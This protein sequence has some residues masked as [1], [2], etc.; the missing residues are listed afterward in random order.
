M[1]SDDGQLALQKALV[2]ALRG[3]TDAGPNVFDRVPSSNPFP[4]VTLGPAQALPNLADCMDGTETFLQ[5][6]VWSRTTG[7]VECKRIAGQVRA[8]LH[9]ATLVLDEHELQMLQVDSVNYLHDPDGQTEHAAMTFRALT[10]PL[11]T[12]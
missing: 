1:A 8:V 2:A 12:T 11:E 10:Q 3:A 6:D 5:I 7:M 9:D 4:R